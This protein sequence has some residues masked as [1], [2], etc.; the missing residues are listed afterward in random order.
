MIFR[1]FTL[2]WMKHI[3]IL[4]VALQ[5]GFAASGAET[6][7]QFP[8]INLQ[9]KVRILSVYHSFIQFIQEVPTLSFTCFR[10]GQTT[11][12]KPVSLWGSMRSLINS[13]SAE[14]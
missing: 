8:E 10:T 11:T 12:R 14:K 5:A 7:T 4:H 6:T 9:E 2:I 3:N 13:S 1:S